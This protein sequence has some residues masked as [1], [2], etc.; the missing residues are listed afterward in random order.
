MKMLQDLA[1]ELIDVT[2]I[3]IAK[4]LRKLRKKVKPPEKL[5]IYALGRADPIGFA[6]GYHSYSGVDIKVFI[7]EPD[8]KFREKY[9]IK[10]NPA[11]KY[12]G[13]VGTVQSVS[14]GK[15]SANKH[16]G[17]MVFVIFDNLDEIE[18]LVN[19]ERRLVIY[20]ANE[21]A[22]NEYGANEYGAESKLI[23]KVIKFDDYFEWGISIDDVVTEATISFTITE[24]KDNETNKD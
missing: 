18:S 8:V 16:G 11:V 4:K 1:L 10:G 20:A 13:A 2:S 19:Q 3:Y 6:R 15:R 14:F 23:N 22:A 17:S 5:P 21:Y 24:D 12:N 7:N 9:E